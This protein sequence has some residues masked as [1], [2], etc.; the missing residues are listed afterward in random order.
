MLA[1]DKLKHND[2]T[3]ERDYVRCDECG[4]EIPLGE[5]TVFLNVTC[6]LTT[7]YRHYHKNICCSPMILKVLADG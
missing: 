5:P 6:G 7:V 2:K 1:T 3:Y 4:Q